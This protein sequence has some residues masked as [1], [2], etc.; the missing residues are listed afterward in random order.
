[1]A[2]NEAVHEKNEELFKLYRLEDVRLS[3][4]FEGSYPAI[5]KMLTKMSAVNWVLET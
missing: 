5:V 3:S 2:E 1:M 4:I